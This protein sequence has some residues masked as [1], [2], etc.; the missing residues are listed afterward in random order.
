MTG[1]VLSGASH[2]FPFH[3][4]KTCVCVRCSSGEWYS[5]KTHLYSIPFLSHQRRISSAISQH[6]PQ[7]LPTTCSGEEKQYGAPFDLHNFP[8]DRDGEPHPPH[9]CIRNLFR[10][11]IRKIRRQEAAIHRTVISVYPSFVPRLFLL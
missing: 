5:R 3:F 10:V 11:Y 1:E 2:H 6:Q 9:P 4:A 8:Q 7:L